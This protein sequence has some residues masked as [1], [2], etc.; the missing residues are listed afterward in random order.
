MFTVI[1]GLFG[2]KLKTYLIIAGILLIT[3][4]VA[5]WYYRHSQAEILAL[6]KAN[7]QLEMAVQE[8]QTTIS[9]MKAKAEKQ[10]RDTAKLQS[11]LTKAEAQKNKL[12]NTLAKHDLTALARK[13][14]TLVQQRM[15]DASK[16]INQDLMKITGA[17]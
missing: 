8:Q 13:K 11:D 15:N 2:S 10:A 6:Q 9:V 14:P 4:G 17:K 1:A 16:K 5:V 7:T 3:I 12:A